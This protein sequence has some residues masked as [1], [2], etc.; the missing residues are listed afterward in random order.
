MAAAARALA[1]PSSRGCGLATDQK[2]VRT[3]GPGRVVL[4]SKPQL[5]TTEKLVS[6][7]QLVRWAG[8]KPQLATIKELV[9]W[10]W[11]ATAK[12]LVSWATKTPRQTP[13]H[14][15]LRNFIWHDY[16]EQVEL[17]GFD[18]DQGNR[19]GRNAF[20]WWVGDLTAGAFPAFGGGQ[21]VADG[22]V[23]SAA[24]TF[25]RVGDQI[26]AVVAKSSK[27]A[28]R[29]LS[30][31]LVEGVAELS[32]RGIITIHAQVGREEDVGRFVRPGNVH[33]QRRVVSITAHN[34]QRDALIARLLDDG[35]D[36]IRHG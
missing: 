18:F 7:V 28:L 16:V 19:P 4:G 26:D 9:S 5:A 21:R 36:V 30:V 6:W 31:F 29:F 20:A 25:D 14:L 15:W 33:Q 12:E 23:V 10:A 17:A 1:T 24:S 3:R 11:R 34:R 35:A 22:F 27:D 2:A 13:R 8:S 32:R